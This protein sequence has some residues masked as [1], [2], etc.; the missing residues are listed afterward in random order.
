VGQVRHLALGDEWKQWDLSAEQ[1]QQV[2]KVLFELLDQFL[3]ERGA[4]PPRSDRTGVVLDRLTVPLA[5]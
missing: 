4:K 5:E 3:A 2:I 1:E